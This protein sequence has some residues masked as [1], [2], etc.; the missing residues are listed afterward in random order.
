MNN[1][2]GCICFTFLHSVFSNLSSKSLDLK[3]QSHIG[4]ICLTFLYC[5]LSNVSSKSL[6]L[7]RQSHIG[8]ICSNFPFSKNK[9][10][11][12]VEEI[13]KLKM[14]NP[15]RTTASSKS[16]ILVED[17]NGVQAPRQVSEQRSCLS[18]WLPVMFRNPMSTLL[19]IFV[20]NWPRWKGGKKNSPPIG[21]V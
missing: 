17:R 10:Y 19:A 8:C 18:M 1:H 11:I 20:N 12:L 21:A 2:I 4:C 9:S 15:T 14:R 7:N 16:C 13:W 5:S 6:D 3:R